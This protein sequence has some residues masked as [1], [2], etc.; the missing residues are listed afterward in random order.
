MNPPNKGDISIE[1]SDSK[2]FLEEEEGELLYIWSPF[3]HLFQSANIIYNQLSKVHWL[4]H[5]YVCSC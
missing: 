5:R 1:P 3:Y 2:I 4:V